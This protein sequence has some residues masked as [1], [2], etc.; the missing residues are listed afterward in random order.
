MYVADTTSQLETGFDVEYQRWTIS[1]GYHSKVEQQL[2][3]HFQ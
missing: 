1:C 2:K 3:Q